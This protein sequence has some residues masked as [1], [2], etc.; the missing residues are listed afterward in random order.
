MDIT[1]KKF[2][3]EIDNRIVIKIPCC[4]GKCDKH[5]LPSWILEPKIYSDI[6]KDNSD[7]V[8]EI[9]LPKK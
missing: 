9:F 8:E 7:I 2:N 6:N 1:S 5:E 4:A 3:K